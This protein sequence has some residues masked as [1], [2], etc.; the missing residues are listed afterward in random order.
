MQFVSFNY[1][2]TF[3]RAGIR[4]SNVVIDLAAAAPL[5]FETMEDVR[6]ELLDILAGQPDGMG[7]DGAVEIAAA[8]LDQLGIASADE[9]DTNIDTNGGSDSSFGDVLSIGGIEMVL[10]MSKV[11]LL[12]PLPRPSS[13]RDFYAFEEHVSTAAR[14]LGRHVPTAWY[15]I[16]TF[17]FTNHTAVYGPDDDIP[18]PRTKALDY[19]LEIACVIGRTGRDI[20][21]E[22]AEN[23][24]AGYTIMNDWSARDVQREEMSIGLGP[25]KGKDFA[26]SLGPALVTLDELE[27]YAL[28][29]GR[30]HLEMVARVNSV[31]RSRGTLRDIYYN[32]AQ[33]IAYASRD[34]TLYP[35]D[36]LGSGTVGTGCLL[37]TTGAQGP[38]LTAGDVVELEITG[39]GVLRNQVVA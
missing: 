7:M 39:L 23:Y 31:E 12:A 9:L 28:N 37:E 38:W 32:F 30:H 11:R 35:G 33:M 14:N 15:E 16:P 2:D 22:D 34:V 18:M 6:W 8:V 24:I 4:L 36:V 26:T 10:P 20:T 17:Y 19:E 27:P 1:G 13:M 3:P 5:A 21:E 25:A 29:D